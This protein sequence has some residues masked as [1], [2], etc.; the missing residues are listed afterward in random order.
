MLERGKIVSRIRDFLIIQLLNAARWSSEL[1]SI[2]LAPVV[3]IL[4]EVKIYRMEDTIYS[5]VA[6]QFC[7]ALLLF[8]R[9]SPRNCRE[10]CVTI[11]DLSVL[12]NT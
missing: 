1:Y 3:S 2:L 11:S 7:Q 4:V 9:M 8:Y 10:L 5:T 6:Y 12:T